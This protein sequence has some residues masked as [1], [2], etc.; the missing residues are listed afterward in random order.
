MLEAIAQYHWLV[1]QNPDLKH[2]PTPVDYSAIRVRVLAS[3]K[4]G[5]QA[6]Q[7]K[8]ATRAIDEF[9]KEISGRHP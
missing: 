3:L 2:S 4:L 1:V 5:K 8:A 6:P 7:Y 9:I